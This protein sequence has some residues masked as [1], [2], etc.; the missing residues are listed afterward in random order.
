[1]LWSVSLQGFKTLTELYDPI[2]L[3]VNRS[4]KWFLYM[5]TGHIENMREPLEPRSDLKNRSN[6]RPVQP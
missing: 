2:R 6:R 3:I 4:S 5:K 1:M